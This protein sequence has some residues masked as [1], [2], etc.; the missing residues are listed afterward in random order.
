MSGTLLAM[1]YCENNSDIDIIFRESREMFS[2]VGHL[3]QDVC[4]MTHSRSCVQ[5][6]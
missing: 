5:I 1:K 6:S 4:S 2:D 3:F